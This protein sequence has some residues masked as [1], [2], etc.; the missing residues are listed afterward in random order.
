[1]PFSSVDKLGQYEIE[2]QIG[3]GGWASCIEPVLCLK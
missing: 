2:A 1:M 3:T